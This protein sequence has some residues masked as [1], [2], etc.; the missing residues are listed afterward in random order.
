MPGRWPACLCA[1]VHYS[2]PVPNVARH[3]RTSKYLRGWYLVDT[4]TVAVTRA[5]LCEGSAVPC[6]ALCP[7]YVRMTADS[8]PPS[9]YIC[10][11][12][13]TPTT[14]NCYAGT[15]PAGSTRMWCATPPSGWPTFS[16]NC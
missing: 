10:S 4:C 16:S 3:S 1:I 5:C 15:V 9:S 14:W 11:K 8:P 6:Q 2:L 12:P 13:R 7:Q